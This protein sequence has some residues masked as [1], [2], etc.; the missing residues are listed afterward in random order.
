[1][2][3]QYIQL[4]TSIESLKTSRS[5]VVLARGYNRGAQIL[6]KCGHQ[7]K[8]PGARIDVNQVTHPEPA[9]IRC[10]RTKFSCP[11]PW[12]AVLVHPPMSVLRVVQ[13][14]DV[15][16]RTPSLQPPGHTAGMW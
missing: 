7:L 15:I 12:R 11:G 1:M 3:F 10:H 4:V 8:I 16:F 5:A 9:N 13:V 2:H 6:C 14:C